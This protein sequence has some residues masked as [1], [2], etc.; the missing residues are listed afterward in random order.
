MKE[1]MLNT[2][3]PPPPGAVWENDEATPLPTL[4]RYPPPSPYF[5]QQEALL[6]KAE[7]KQNKNNTDIEQFEKMVPLQH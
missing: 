4:Q 5:K 2:R 3:K 1:H 6:P 7:Q